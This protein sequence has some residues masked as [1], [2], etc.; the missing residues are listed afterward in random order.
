V[1]TRGQSEDAANGKGGM[2][3]SEVIEVGDYVRVVVN[4]EYFSAK[5]ADGAIGVVRDFFS[6]LSGSYVEFSTGF[7]GFIDDELELVD[8]NAL[9]EAE[10]ATV[11]PFVAGDEVVHAGTSYMV[12]RTDGEICVLSDAAYFPPGRK[13]YAQEFEAHVSEVAYDYGLCADCETPLNRD[14]TCRVCAERGCAD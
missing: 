10:N 8:V 3:M 5:P 13:S 7:F 11:N 9:T 14:G 1:L 6:D 12:V 2:V 4:T